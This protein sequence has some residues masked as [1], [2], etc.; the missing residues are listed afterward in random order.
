[1]FRSGFVGVTL[2]ALACG[3][4]A[5]PSNGPFEPFAF[6]SR[7]DPTRTR[8]CAAANDPDSEP[9]PLH[10]TC[11]LEGEDLAPDAALGPNGIRLLA[12][13]LERGY[14]LDGQ[15]AWLAS[16]DAPRPDVV[17]LSEADRGC[18]RTGYRHVAREWADAL[19]MDYV[20]A[21]EFEEV[22]F[23]DAGAITEVCEHG[24]AL[25]ARAPM[26][27]VRQ[28]RFATTDDWNA[29]PAE[30][31]YPTGTRFGGRVAIRA[32]LAIGGRR[33]RVYGMHLA[34]GASE[35]AI[36]RAQ[37]DEIVAD[38][39]PFVGPVV[40]TGDL[41]TFFY[42]L[43]LDLGSTV[44]SVTQALLAADFVDAH[45]TIPTAMRGTDLEFGLIIDLAFGRDVAFEDAWIGD[46]ASVGMLSDHLPIATTIR[47]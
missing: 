47:F 29:L 28:L 30:R 20:F 35:D 15:L 36:R 12:Y 44:E 24:N 13:N 18:S 26:G 42:R 10:P 27:N 39:E 40:V 6:G 38:A 9:D 8:L 46:A 33:V 34:S 7:E 31:V 22:S 23:D 32:D 37:M 16:P 3:C 21:V 45:L 25:L 14:Q 1:M 11:R 2:A 4:A 41:N 5:G 43:D 19:G 17:V